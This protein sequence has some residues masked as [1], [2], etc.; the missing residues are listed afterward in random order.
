MKK[1]RDPTEE[2][3]IV[4]IVAFMVRSMINTKQLIKTIDTC[5]TV[6]SAINGLIQKILEDIGITVSKNSLRGVFFLKSDVLYIR[7]FMYRQLDIISHRDAISRKPR[8]DIRRY[9]TFVNNLFYPRLK[10]LMKN[11]EDII[12][13][14]THNLMCSLYRGLRETMVNWAKL[15]GKYGISSESTVIDYIDIYDQIFEFCGESPDEYILRTSPSHNS[16]TEDTS[17]LANNIAQLQAL[18]PNIYGIFL[19]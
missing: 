11:R 9:E 14:Y 2:S 6:Y 16:Y 12:E 17:E 1:T 5:T 15:P 8:E 3:A 19:Q 7:L 13:T 18:G 10:T 4:G